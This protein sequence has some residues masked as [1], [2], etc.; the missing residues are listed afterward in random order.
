LQYY[1]NT[2]SLRRNWG[3][4]VRYQENLITNAMANQSHEALAICDRF[5]DWL[6]GNAQSCCTVPGAPDCPVGAEMGGFS[7]VEG[8]RAMSRIATVL[9]NHSAAARYERLAI[10][11]KEEFHSYFYDP[12][13]G[14]YGGDEGAIQSLTLPALLIGSPPASVYPHVVQTVADDIQAIN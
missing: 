7:Y 2:R 5:N 10:A 12:V 6:C 8:L 3:S 13:R 4:L 9:G 14:R 11:G 1:G